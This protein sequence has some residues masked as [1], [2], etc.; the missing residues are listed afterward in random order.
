MGSFDNPAENQPAPSSVPQDTSYMMRPVDIDPRWLEVEQLVGVQP[1]SLIEFETDRN[2]YAAAHPEVFQSC[3]DEPSE[4]SKERF[5]EEWLSSRH[6]LVYI[7]RHTFAEDFIMALGDV[8][9]VNAAHISMRPALEYMLVPAGG[10]A[11]SKAEDLL[12]QYGLSLFGFNSLYDAFT[13]FVIPAASEPR[14][15]QLL[16][17]L[18]VDTNI[19]DA[20]LFLSLWPWLDT[21]TPRWVDDWP[22]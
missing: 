5:L 14:L 10:K 3:L 17:E 7:D 22:T 20:G 6:D 12:N 13:Y 21:E 2:A 18:E 9:L 16:R 15:D 4:F 1:G 11:I 8:T 19:Y